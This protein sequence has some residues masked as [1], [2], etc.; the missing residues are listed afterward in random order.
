MQLQR[1]RKTNVIGVSI[2]DCHNQPKTVLDPPARTVEWMNIYFI[3]FENTYTRNNLQ[4]T[5]GA[6][7]DFTCRKNSIE[8]DK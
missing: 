7:I 8:H 6:I 2:P 5:N 4:M 3:I 1:A